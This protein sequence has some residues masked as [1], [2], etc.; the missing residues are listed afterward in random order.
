MLNMLFV[1]PMV[2]PTV[3]PAVR[4]RAPANRSRTK[5]TNLRT[6]SNHELRR[7]QRRA[8]CQPARRARQRERFGS[9]G[10]ADGGRQDACPTLQFMES[11][12]SFMI[13]HWDHDPTPNPSQEGI[14]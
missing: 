6:H 2:R 8:G 14:G 4:A 1:Q 12:V 3:L 5:K 10:V 9:V 11:L 7:A 13:R